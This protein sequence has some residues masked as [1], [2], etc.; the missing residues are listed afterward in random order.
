MPFEEAGSA[1]KVQ[2]IKET[3]YAVVLL[4]GGNR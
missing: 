4:I 3:D 1:V 2:L